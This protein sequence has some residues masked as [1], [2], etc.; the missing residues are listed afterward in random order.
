MQCAICNVQYAMCNMQCAICNVQYA[1]CNMQCAMCNMQCAICNV[2][3]AMCNEQHAI[4]KIIRLNTSHQ[5]MN[6]YSLNMLAWR[7][8]FVKLF[9]FKIVH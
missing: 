4:K 5:W 3:Y 7:I 6:I 2:Q 9:I 1:M 8:R